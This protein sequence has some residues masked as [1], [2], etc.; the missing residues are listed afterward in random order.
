MIPATTTLITGHALD[1]LHKMP[2]GSIHCGV[3]SSPY[4]GP[5][6]YETNPIIWGGDPTCQ[7]DWKDVHPPG[8][9]SS[10]TFPGKLQP[11]GTFNRENRTSKICTKCGAWEGELGH[12]PT[13]EMF[14]DHLVQ[15]YSELHRVLRDD[16][17]F[18][19]NI[20]DSRDDDKNL[21]FIPWKLAEALKKNGWILHCMLPWLKRNS[22]PDSDKHR[23]GSSIEYVLFLTKTPSITRFWT[24]PDKAAVRIKPAPDLRWYNRVTHELLTAPPEVE[25]W[26]D[27]TYMD[28][29]HKRKVWRKFNLWS[30]NDYYYDH[31]AVLQKA[32]ESYLKDKR[33][34]NVIRQCVNTNSKYPDEGQY[35]KKQDLVGKGNYVGFNARYVPNEFGLRFMRDSDFF[36]KTW[37]GLLQNEDGEPMALV[38]NP[39]G[40]RGAHLAVFPPTLVE[41]L[42]LAGTSCKGVCLICGAPWVRLDGDPAGVNWM[43]SCICGIGQPMVPATVLDPFGGA[44]T[45]GLVCKAHNRNYIGI[46]LNPK[47][48]EMAEKRIQEEK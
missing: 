37:Q 14:I 28:G 12:E 10:D 5:R 31:I 36:F 38:I 32:S 33:P 39:T 41:P 17:S 23:P 7:H 47:Y 34:R 20:G 18:F 29:I 40:Y 44:G 8:Y 24:H 11:A 27:L 9:R 46:D 13:P 26:K 2:T 21:M 43:P 15:I 22:M 30:S 4:L 1:V 35:A 45:T 16:G 25:G 6:G 48:N 3:T 19:C 42:I